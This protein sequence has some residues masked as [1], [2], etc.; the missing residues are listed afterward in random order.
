MRVAIKGDCVIWL[1]N[2]S[3][4]VVSIHSPMCSVQEPSQRRRKFL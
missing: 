3:N 4:A 1:I 2:Q